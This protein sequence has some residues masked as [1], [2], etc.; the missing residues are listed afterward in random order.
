MNNFASL[1]TNANVW[2]VFMSSSFLNWNYLS[3]I[4]AEKSCCKEGSDPRSRKRFAWNDPFRDRKGEILKS[5]N[6]ARLNRGDGI[7][8][9]YITMRINSY[10][11]V[12]ITVTVTKANLPS[13]SREKNCSH[14]S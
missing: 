10:I 1:E 7:A 13:R 6:E 4:P 8:Q 2:R 11:Y 9:P 3:S 14:I 5:H 12:R